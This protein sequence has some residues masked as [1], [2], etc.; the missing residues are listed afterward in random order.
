M[1]NY[2]HQETLEP[3]ELQGPR[4]SPW[5]APGGRLMLQEEVPDHRAGVNVFKLFSSWGKNRI[6][7]GK[8]K[9]AILEGKGASLNR[10]ASGLFE[11]IWLVSIHWFLVITVNF[12]KRFIQGPIMVDSSILHWKQQALTFYGWFSSHIKN[13]EYFVGWRHPLLVLA[14]KRVALGPR[15]NQEGQI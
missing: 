9:K 15:R 14:A 13:T 10:L 11:Y 4:Q 1:F 5:D 3:E 8:G 12:V 6:I 2:F 7:S